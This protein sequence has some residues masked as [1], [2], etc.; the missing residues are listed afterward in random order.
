MDQGPFWQELA[1][2]TDRMKFLRDEGPRAPIAFRAEVSDSLKLAL[3]L[4]G[5]RAWIEQSS[6]GLLKWESLKHNEQPYVKISAA[7]PNR[8][9]WEKLAIFYAATPRSLTVTINEAALRRALDREANRRHAI[10]K[11]KAGNGQSDDSTPK[12]AAPASGE[13]KPW[14]G[15]SMVLQAG[16][17][18][19]NV[20]E[21]ICYEDYQRVM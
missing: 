4:A 10:A 21:A 11:A 14:L 1:K 2:K 16:R 15:S 9:G 6:P 7:D 20:F 5:L 18:A 19:L 3:V 8:S 17:H 13:I 12:P